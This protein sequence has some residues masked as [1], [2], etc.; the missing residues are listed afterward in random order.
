MALLSGGKDSCYNILKC[1]Q[2]GHELVCLANLFPED[3]AIDELNSFM[4]QSAAHQVIPLFE[5]CFNVPLFRQAI[6][7]GAMSQQLDYLPNEADEVEDLFVLL[8][9]VKQT[10]PDITGVSCGAIVSNYQRFRV[11]SVCQRLGLIP[12]TYMWQRD[13]QE[14]LDEMLHS[15]MTA[16]FVKVAGAGLDPFK[17]LGKTLASQRSTLQKFHENFGLDLCGKL[18]VLALI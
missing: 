4:Y 2:N 10:Y 1:V 13:R 11:E 3:E 14:L 8:Q 15:Q 5:Q 9:H 17:Q 16:I 18:L 12:I 7:N 6:K